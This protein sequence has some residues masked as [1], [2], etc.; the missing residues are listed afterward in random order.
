MDSHHAAGEFDAATPEA[1]LHDT[2]TTSTSDVQDSPAVA[3]EELP[4]ENSGNNLQAASCEQMPQPTIDAT[5]NVAATSSISG[6][7]TAL[8]ASPL[9]TSISTCTIQLSNPAGNT[10]NTTSYPATNGN[11]STTSSTAVTCETTPNVEGMV[12]CNITQHS[13]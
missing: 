6:D 3:A 10:S 4:Q 5:T 12:Y 1:M 7:N 2:S 8:P 11:T 13:G 9:T